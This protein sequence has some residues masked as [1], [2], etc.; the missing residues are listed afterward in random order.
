MSFDT[1]D[2]GW[3]IIICDGCGE[4]YETKCSNN[5]E[6]YYEARDFDGWLALPDGPRDAEWC[7]Y[8]PNCKGAHIR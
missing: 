3:T 7:H 2:N 4:E 6:A 5:I 8:C 1:T